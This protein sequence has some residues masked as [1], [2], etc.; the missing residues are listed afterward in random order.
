MSLTMALFFLV[1]LEAVTDTGGSV[2]A[3]LL[4]IPGTGPNAATVIDG[5]PMNQKGKGG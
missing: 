5:F 4:N 2:T 3:I 1:S